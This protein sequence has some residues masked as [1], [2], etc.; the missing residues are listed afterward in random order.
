[1]SVCF[2]SGVTLVTPTPTGL[3][4]QFSVPLKQLPS[5]PS[6]SMYE[7]FQHFHHQRHLRVLCMKSLTFLQQV[8]LTLTKASMHL[9]FVPS[10]QPSSTTKGFMH[11]TFDGP[12]NNHQQQMALYMK[13][14][15][16]FKTTTSIGNRF[17][18]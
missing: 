12:F 13:P 7:N 6:G 14:L 9:I 5:T 17:Q 4:M 16:A 18:G 3:S 10:K 11:E 8:R 2:S 15:M 1:M